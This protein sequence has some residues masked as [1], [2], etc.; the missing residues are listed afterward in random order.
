M[1]Y[2]YWILKPISS[3]QVIYIH[4]QLSNVENFGS[5]FVQVQKE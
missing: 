3:E 4:S 5:E 2:Y 1:Q